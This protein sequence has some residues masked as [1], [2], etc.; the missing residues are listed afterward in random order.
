M[1]IIALLFVCSY[2][3]A[4]NSIFKSLARQLGIQAINKVLRQEIN[5]DDAVRKFLY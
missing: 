1:E 4:L 5:D 3:D 2:T